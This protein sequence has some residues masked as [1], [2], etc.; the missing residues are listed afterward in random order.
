MLSSRRGQPLQPHAAGSD[1]GAA[2]VVR[3]RQ[4]APVDYRN[5]GPEKLGSVYES[6]LE[7]VPEPD[8]LARSFGFV[9]ADGE[10]STQGN[11]R[12]I[13]GSYYTPG[14]LVQ[15]L[16]KNAL[17]PV[18]TARLSEA[19]RMASGEWPHPSTGR[20]SSAPLIEQTMILGKQILTLERRINRRS[21]S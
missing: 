18:I 13:S 20:F 14:S 16:I 9:G 15:D 21:E 19:G 12:K 11:V 4:V 6:L 5:M 1:A 2:L 10:G 3:Q 7:L 8:P 17:D